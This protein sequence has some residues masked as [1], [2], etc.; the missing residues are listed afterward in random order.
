M[1]I[2]FVLG[3]SSIIL[4]YMRTYMYMYMCTVRMHVMTSIVNIP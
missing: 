3:K 4:A 1:G 2:I